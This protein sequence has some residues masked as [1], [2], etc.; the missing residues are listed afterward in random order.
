MELRLSNLSRSGLWASGRDNWC[1]F[2]TCRGGG[3]IQ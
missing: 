2:L 3:G 1:C